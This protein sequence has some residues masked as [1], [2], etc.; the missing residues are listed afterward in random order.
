MQVKIIHRNPKEYIED[1][2]QEEIGNVQEIE[3]Q[4]QGNS[5]D[6][7]EVEQPAEDTYKN[8]YTISF[9]D[10]ILKIAITTKIF[11]KD[12]DCSLDIDLSN[13]EDKILELM[14]R[15]NSEK[16]VIT[17]YEIFKYLNQDSGIK[18]IKSVGEKIARIL[19]D[20]ESD[21]I[22]VYLNKACKNIEGFENIQIDEALSS[23]GQLR[24]LSTWFDERIQKVNNKTKLLNEVDIYKSV[25]YLEA[26]VDLLTRVI[27]E[28][29]LTTN[30]ADLLKLADSKS[31]LNIKPLTDIKQELE[32]NK[33]NFR[34]L[35]EKYYGR[36]HTEK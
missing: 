17:A 26:Q 34:T 24:K 27:L 14:V 15:E 23:T 31:V 5:P 18:N 10:N 22:Y 19:I 35:Q 20:T 4:E 29:N 1:D 7:P 16:I 28:A 30:Y 21:T 9:K 2:K 13:P 36:I 32:E 6:I 3:S 8:P 11:N 33:G 25:A 12:V